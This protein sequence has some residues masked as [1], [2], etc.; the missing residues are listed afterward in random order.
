VGIIVAS[1]CNARLRPCASIK[2]SRAEGGLVRGHAP[3]ALAAGVA[4]AA[5]SLVR[6]L[7]AAP[8][9]VQDSVV[10]MARP[11]ALA[12]AIALWIG[13]PVT[14]HAQ[15]ISGSVFEDVNYGGGAGRTLAGSFGTVRS[16]ARVELFDNTGAFLTSTTTDGSGNYTFAGLSAANYTVRVVSSSVTSSRTGY[17]ASLL[18][19]MTYRTDASTGTAT[20]VTNYVGG[21]DPATADA[22]DAASGWTLDT[23]TGVFSG[24]GSGKAH[25]FAP[26]TVSAANVTGVDFGWNF[27]TIVNVNDTGQGSLRQFITNANALGGEASLAQSGSRQVNGANQAL[28]TGRETSLFMVPDG[29]AHAGLRAG[30]ASQLTAGVARIVPATDLPTVTGAGTFIDGT[31]QTVNVGNTNAVVLGTGGTVGVDALA[32]SQVRGPEVEIRDIASLENGIAINANDVAVRG[33][34]ILGFATN[35]AGGAAVRIENAVSGAL[36][37]E[38]ILGAAATSFVDPGIALRNWHN[39]YGDGGDAA[40]VRRNLIGFAR[41][42]GMQLANAADSWSIT[43]NEIRDNGLETGDGD[44]IALSGSTLVD[45]TGNL[46]VGSSSQ[47]YVTTNGSTSNTATNNTI[48]GNGVGIPTVLIQS[49]GITIRGTATAHTISRNRITAN[50]GAGLAVNNG[51]SVLSFRRTR[52]SQM[53]RLPLDS[54]P[55]RQRRSAST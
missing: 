29:A 31:T 17:V 16:G 39:V 24:G 7:R 35:A 3:V 15:S 32:L 12:L 26:V 6:A 14:A 44:G 43:D 37:E 52:F 42:R 36:I 2:E 28:P 49:S 50:Y 40:I 46:I 18:P 19:V 33:M 9:L 41:F 10:A 34:A 48:S 21:H 54:A 47:G 25:A 22:A 30:L 23:A 20:A 5:R 13:A 53:A 55:R 45:T 38:N 8:D 4:Q 1:S 51:A 27:D 11:W